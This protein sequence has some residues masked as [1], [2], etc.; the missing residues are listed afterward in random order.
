MRLTQIA[1]A[2]ESESYSPEVFV[3]LRDEA[4]NAKGLYRTTMIGA[5]ADE[6][7][8]KGRAY[9]EAVE[10]NLLQGK[11]TA[12]RGQETPSEQSRKRSTEARAGWK[13]HIR[14]LFL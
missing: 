7:G 6:E 9:L 2:L 5:V 14:D 8:F 11:E 12:E 13:R 4:G 1:R 3:L 10:P